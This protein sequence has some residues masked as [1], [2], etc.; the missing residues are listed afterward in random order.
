MKTK[1]KVGSKVKFRNGERS[2]VYKIDS[3]DFAS[4]P[5]K[6]INQKSVTVE[7]YYSFDEEHEYDIV[8]IT[9]HLYEGE[10]VTYNDTLYIFYNNGLIKFEKYGI[11]GKII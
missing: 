2:V 1:F 9:G 8:E 11:N 6:T 7:G 4:F 10:E 5:I 3:K